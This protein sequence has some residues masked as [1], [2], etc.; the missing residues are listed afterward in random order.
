V[1]YFRALRDL[2]EIDARA[3]QYVAIDPDTG[4]VT[5]QHQPPP[6]IALRTLVDVTAADVELVSTGDIQERDVQP[7]LRALAEAW[8]LSLS[9]AK[10]PRATRKRKQSKNHLSLVK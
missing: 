10:A 6:K 4:R 8:G 2:P 9:D 1:I 5:V 3:G 7:V